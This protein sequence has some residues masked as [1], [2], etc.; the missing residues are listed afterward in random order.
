MQ[1]YTKKEVIMEGYTNDTF[2]VM[3]EDVEKHFEM[4]MWRRKLFKVDV[5][6]DMLWNLYLDSYP[7]EMQSI[8]RENR[9][10]DCTACRRWFR[11]M[12]NVV[13]LDDD[14]TMITMFSCNTLPQYQSILDKLEEQI[15]D[16]DIKE[17]FLSSRDKIG[18][19]VTY[20]EDENGDIERDYHFFSELPDKVI[21]EGVKVGQEKDKLYTARQLLERSL[22]EISLT[23]LDTV[24]DLIEDNNLYRGQQWKNQLELFRGLKIAYADVTDDKRNNW[25]WLQS[26][27]VGRTVAGIKNHSIGVLLND[28]SDGVDIETAL[29]R[30]E[31]VVAPSNYQRPKAVFTQKMLDDAKEKITELGYLDS[32][33]RRYA[34]MDDVS[35]NDVLFANRNLSSGLKDTDDLFDELAKDT[36]VKHQSFDYVE[37]IDI[38]DFI[39][40]VLPKAKEV[41]LYNEAL[42]SSKFVS[43]IAPVN[44]DAPSM[45]KWDN[46]FSWVYKNNISDSMKEQVKALGGDVDV[47]L[48]FTIR[49]NNGH[50]WDKNDLDA[51]CV[52]PN[53]NTI[54]FGASTSSLTGGWLDVDIINPTKGTPAVEN[55]QYKT[56]ER[57]SY[58][59]YLFR[60]HQYSYRGGDE[61]FEA[62]IE[63]DGNIYNF[64]YPFKLSQNE[65]VDVAKV[66]LHRDGTFELISLLDNTV[67]NRSIWNVKLN[68]FIPVTFICYSPNYWGDN[69][70]GNQH[71]FFMLQ[72]CQNDDRPNAWFNEY[73]N[74]ELREHRQVME[75]LGTKAR[76]EES[77]NQLSGIGFSLTQHAKFK[78]K[79][80]VDDTEKIY[81]VMV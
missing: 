54:F 41:S 28:L 46:P 10:Q 61:G 36:V 57:M 79:V 11:K 12:A 39:E 5:D 67:S 29:K 58:G 51:H 70:V 44:A 4:E 1:G 19:P 53:G 71:V 23:A 69:Q 15:L 52:E 50:E 20:T 26:M 33:S 40:N 6:T 35:I 18:V 72:D 22:D 74:S 13:A 17:A 68:E 8:Y 14:G 43:L 47:D 31:Q 62:E 2:K 21:Y 32:L 56:R 38:N 49:W 42:L 55:I 9:W 77:E 64:N 24:L 16:K 60:V 37:A 80:L 30:Y 25:L 34:K 63:F 27:K 65:K 75:A 76:V 81:Q 45:F 78:V 3:S 73:L 66:V 48:R 59:E 7:E